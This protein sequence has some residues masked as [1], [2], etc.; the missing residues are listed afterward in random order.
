MAGLT[1]LTS[2]YTEST[3]TV[4]FT[5]IM[6]REGVVVGVIEGREVALGEPEV[7]G[8]PVAE[9]EARAEA[10]RAPEAVAEAH[11]DPVPAARGEGVCGKL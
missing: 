10:E 1:S 7:E 8:E 4:F 3:P 2:E 5:R 11:G 9:R 6:P